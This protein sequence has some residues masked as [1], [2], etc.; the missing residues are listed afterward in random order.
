MFKTTFDFH[1]IFRFQLPVSII[2]CNY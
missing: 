1:A 2:W